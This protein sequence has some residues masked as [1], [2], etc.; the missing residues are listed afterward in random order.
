MDGEAGPWV[1]DLE[2]FDRMF[3][4]DRPAQKDQVALADLAAIYG[5]ENILTGKEYQR[6]R[7]RM[8]AAECRAL[9]RAWRQWYATYGS[10]P[11]FGSF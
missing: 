6:A 2:E 10:K 8:W 5:E 9:R 4:P 1:P 7:R 3:S 11:D